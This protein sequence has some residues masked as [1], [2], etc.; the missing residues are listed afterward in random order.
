MTNLDGLSRLDGPALLLAVAVAGLAGSWHCAGMCG[1]FA[2]IASR[3]R[4]LSRTAAYHAGRLCTYVAL[5]TALHTVGLGFRST[6]HWLGIPRAGV[7][8]FV[9]LLS[10]WAGLLASGWMERWRWLSR[11]SARIGA[12]VGRRQRG[13][14]LAGPAGAWV[15]GATSTLLPC[16]WLYGFLFVAASRQD[17]WRAWLVMLV[18][19]TTNIPWLLASGEILGWIRRRLGRWSRPAGAVFLAVVVAVATWKSLPRAEVVD[20]IPGQGGA[21]CCHPKDHR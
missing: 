6:F 14:D 5:A 3:G 8:A 11:F 15:L 10:A 19:W 12:W 16:I 1:P 20:V 17:L 18:F 9:F 2:G 4:D 7:F 13:F 21:S